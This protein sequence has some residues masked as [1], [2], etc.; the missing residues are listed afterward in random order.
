MRI[1][2][3]LMALAITLWIVPAVLAFTI[4]RSLDGWL[5]VV[6]EFGIGACVATWVFLRVLGRQ[7][8]RR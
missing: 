7:L 5:P 4:G 8:Q 6:L 3:A 2:P 1:V